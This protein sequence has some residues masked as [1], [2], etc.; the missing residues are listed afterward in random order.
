MLN[1][2]DDA[3]MR[4]Y[5]HEYVR[6]QQAQAD[7]PLSLQ[8]ASEELMMPLPLL[9]AMVYDYDLLKQRYGPPV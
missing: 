1:E 4:K 5:F 9:Q 8:E 3:A 6:L 7:G 2:T